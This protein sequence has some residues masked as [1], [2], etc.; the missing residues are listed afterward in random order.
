MHCAEQ[1]QPF[2]AAGS[3]LVIVHVHEQQIELFVRQPGQNGVRGIDRTALHSLA[4]T[5]QFDRVKDLRLIVANQYL[6]TR[7]HVNSPLK[8]RSRR[9]SSLELKV[10]GDQYFVTGDQ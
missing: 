8:K 4:R 2:L 7:T 6:G 3:I 10:I 5:N 1:V 9:Y